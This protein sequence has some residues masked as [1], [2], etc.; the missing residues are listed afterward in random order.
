MELLVLKLCSNELREEELLELELRLSLCC[1]K[2]A[3]P[4]AFGE[5]EASS[6]ITELAE[7]LSPDDRAATIARINSAISA[8]L[9]E[10]VE[11]VALAFAED[12][13]P[14]AMEVTVCTSV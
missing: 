5:T 11:L 4:L 2:A 1:C 6:D 9:E 8:E 12:T 13:A 7:E 10:V 3:A 14:C